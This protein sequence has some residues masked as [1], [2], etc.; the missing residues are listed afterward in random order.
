MCRFITKPSHNKNTQNKPILGH[1]HKP[2]TQLPLTTFQ[3]V[4][5]D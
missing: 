4:D 3:K 2:K 5:V 1:F